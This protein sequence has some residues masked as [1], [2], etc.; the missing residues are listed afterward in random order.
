MFAALNFCLTT[1]QLN[2]APVERGPHEEPLKSAIL[3][4]NQTHEGY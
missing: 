2:F 1:I 3:N 4:V